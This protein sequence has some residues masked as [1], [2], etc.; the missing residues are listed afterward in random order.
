MSIILYIL[1]IICPSPP[2]ISHAVIELPITKN[3]T[4]GTNVTYS[5][6]PD[7][8]TGRVRRFDDGSVTKDIFCSDDGQWSNSTLQCDSKY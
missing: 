2:L 1:V 3:F 6:V 5:C 4:Y 7:N 8:L